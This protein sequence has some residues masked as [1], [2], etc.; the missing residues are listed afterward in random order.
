MLSKEIGHSAK[1]LERTLGPSGNPTAD[2][3]RIEGY[4]K[5]STN[6]KRYFM[7]FGAIT[8]A[9]AYSI[10]CV[11]E[12]ICRQRGLG[13]L[14]NDVRVGDGRTIPASAESNSPVNSPTQATV[15]WSPCAAWGKQEL[16]AHKEK[17]PQ[18]AEVTNNSQGEQ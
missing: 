10:R 3:P 1:S 2:N 9:A 16:T 17:R 7:R 14:F 15:L 8:S 6:I 12:G 5:F 11:L 4:V 13:L 18:A